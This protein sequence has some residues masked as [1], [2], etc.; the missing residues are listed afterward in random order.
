MSTNGSNL[1]LDR[2]EKLIEQGERANKEAHARHD[3]EMA[4]IRAIGRKTR[5]DMRRWTALGVME[6][7]RHRKK[8]NDLDAKS[9]LFRAHTDEKL[10]EIT[11]KLDGLIGYVD[12]LRKPGPV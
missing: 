3:R 4:E 6:S 7:R 9:A 8:I 5:D 1:R 12:G 10:A 11:D 2:I